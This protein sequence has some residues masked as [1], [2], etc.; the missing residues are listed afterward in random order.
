MSEPPPYLALDTS[1]PVGSIAVGRAGRLLAEVVLGVAT[2]HAESLLPAVD[3][4][5]ARAGVR[6]ADLAGIVV[7]GGPGSF[8]GIRIAGAAAKGFARALGVPLFA[9]SG[10]LALAA[11]SASADRPV[12]A[13]F[14]ARR[15]EVYSACYAFPGLAAVEERLAPAPRPL[16]TVLALLA[17]AAPLYVGDGALAHRAAIES[18]GGLV[19]PAHMAAPRAGALLWLA[20]V[21]PAGLVRH[22]EAWEPE[23]LRPSG[24]ERN[25]ACG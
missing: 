14:D 5:L 25:A 24:A 15:G 20:D 18:A 3:F 4:V 21:H 1:T 6:P 19:A 10:L 13:L 11:A 23:Y 2:R 7:A 8:T 22:P 12:C 9:Y 17:D 16:G